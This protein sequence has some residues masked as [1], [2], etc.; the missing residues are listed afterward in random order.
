MRRFISL[1][2]LVAMCWFA[3]YAAHATE[4]KVPQGV[5]AGTSA[6][7][8]TSGSGDADFYLIGPSHVFKRSVKLGQDIKLAANDLGSAGEYL[9]MLR[10]DGSTVARWFYVRAAKPADLAF[11]AKP[12]RVP[13]AQPRAISGSVFVFDGFQNLVLQPTTVKFNLSLAGIPP[14]TRTETTKNGVAAV[15]LDSSRTAGPAQFVVATE[16]V[17]VRR[18]VQETASEPCNLR[19]KA[20]RAKNSIVLETEPVRDCAGNLVPDGTIVTFTAVEPDNHKSTVDARVKRGVAR[21]E[22]PFIDRAAIS[23]ASGVVVGNELRWG[24]GQ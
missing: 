8:G 15:L 24:G 1:V 10:K 19:I 4:L 18:V 11:V 16:D 9:A 22:L 14:I 5:I 7:I 12:S 23:A 13:A 3:A 6:S 20:E 17:T 21:V 2:W